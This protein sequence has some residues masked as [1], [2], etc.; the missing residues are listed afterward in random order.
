MSNDFESLKGFNFVGEP[1][2]N[3]VLEDNIITFLDWGLL[4]KGNYINV[5]MDSSGLYG[6]DRHRLRLV[7]DPNYTAGQVWEGYKTN[8][9]WE[10]GIT[11]DTPPVEISGVTVDSVFYPTS[12]IANPHHV[13]Y[14]DGRVVFDTALSIGSVVEAAYAYKWINVA[15]ADGFPWFKEIQ[16]RSER[17]ESSDFLQVGSGI[18]DQLGQTRLQPP[19]IAVEITENT[20]F[21]PYQLGGG[22]YTFTDVLFHVVAEDRYL[23]D[24][25]LNIISFQNDKNIH[26]FDTNRMSAENRWPLDYRGTIASGSLTYPDLVAVSGAGGFRRDTGPVMFRN[27]RGQ[28]KQQIHPYL[29]T[30][31]IR[32]TIEAI[33]PSI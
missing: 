21:E 9:V 27:M 20:R 7:D 29:Y 19:A 12:G 11:I 28:R 18:W 10:S 4:K 30:G 23:R 26:L 33:E 14:P 15:P 5:E 13:D 31:V 22:Q 24:K 1:T 3:S 8:W 6:G 32:C 17:L 25:M 2:F 16:Y